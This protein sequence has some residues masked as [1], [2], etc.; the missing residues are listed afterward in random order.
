MR[1]TNCETHLRELRFH[2]FLFM[3]E[4]SE[5]VLQQVRK[6]EA[7]FEEWLAKAQASAKTPK[8]QTAVRAIR[9]GY[10]RY[11]RDLEKLRREAEKKGP[12]KELH[13]LVL[14]H[15]IRHII[16]PCQHYAQLNEELIARAS[17]ESERAGNWA[18]LTLLLLGV[19]GPLGGLL[20][21]YGIARGLSRSLLSLS[22]RV[23]DMAQHLETDIGAVKLSRTRGWSNWTSSSITWWTGWWRWSTRLH[24]QQAEVLRAQQ[25]SAVGQ[26]AASVA[27]E[28]RNP[29]TSI[30]ML[31]EAG[32]G[33]S[34]P[35]PFTRENLQV[36]H[37]EILRLEQTVQSFLDFARPPALKRIGC[38]LRTVIGRSVEL[39]GTRARQQ[40]VIIEWHPRRPGF[41][42]SS[43]KAS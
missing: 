36:I 38:D 4:P 41:T 19:G 39:V 33:I 37:A 28:V 34:K 11:Q 8:E 43:M 7:R 18:Q 9:T 25:L 16:D 30:K 32:L 29:L 6:D 14:D 27:H 2:S 31:V 35:R 17:Q 10:Q 13:K 40:Q 15:P 42:P 12:P 20:S 23:Q 21:G 26:L 3:V 1:P 22:V 5:T 24:R